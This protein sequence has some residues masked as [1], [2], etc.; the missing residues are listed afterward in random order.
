MQPS[1]S[2]VADD[3]FDRQD[4]AELTIELAQSD[5]RQVARRLACVQV[6]GLGLP[7]GLCMG[8]RDVL[9]GSVSA[10]LTCAGCGMS[11]A[12]MIISL[13]LL[14]RRGAWAR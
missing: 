3:R 4:V 5:R 7:C 11:R 10:L 8:N 9:P 13:V 12:L 1:G 14:E 6:P 2:A